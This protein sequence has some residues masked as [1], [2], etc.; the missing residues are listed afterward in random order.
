MC[1]GDRK[2]LPYTL[3]VVARYMY[4]VSGFTGYNA[5]NVCVLYNG[6]DFFGGCAYNQR[7]GQR[8][9]G[10][11]SKRMWKMMFAYKQPVQQNSF[12]YWFSPP[13]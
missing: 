7:R 4:I 3:A 9:F 1:K 6:L 10:R 13:A 11:T 5:H 12:Y 2:G 8:R